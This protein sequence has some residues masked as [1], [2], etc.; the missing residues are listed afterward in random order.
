MAVQALSAADELHELD[1]RGFV[2]HDCCIA[3]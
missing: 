3:H 1:L 2:L